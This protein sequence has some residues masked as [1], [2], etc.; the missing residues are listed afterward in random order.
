MATTKKTTTKKTVTPQKRV[1]KK[2]PSKSSTQSKRTTKKATVHT[3][4]PLK[5]FRLTND[6]PEFTTFKITRQ[7]IYWI[8]ILGTIIFF[9]LWIL[10]LQIEISNLLEAQLSSIE[11]SL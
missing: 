7:T 11:N 4:A 10:S 3:Q 6:V 2:T 8:I 1:V 5:S 9:Q